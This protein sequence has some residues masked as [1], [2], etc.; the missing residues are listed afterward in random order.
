[1]REKNLREVNACR[2]RSHGVS[3]IVGKCFVLTGSC[4]R[5]NFATDERWYAA[6]RTRFHLSSRGDKKHL[7]RFTCPKTPLRELQEPEPSGKG[8]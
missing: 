8:G 6:S 1:M 4:E 3:T 7:S 5:D 2:K